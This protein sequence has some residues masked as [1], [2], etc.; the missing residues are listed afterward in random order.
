VGP[1]KPQILGI[2]DG[3]L[4][5]A[6]YLPAIASLEHLDFEADEGLLL[7]AYPGE[8]GVEIRHFLGRVEPWLKAGWRILA[9]RPE[10]YP[11]G[12]AV[13]DPSFF[14]LEDR[15]FAA[16]GAN[17]L[18]V[19]PHIRHPERGQLSFARRRLAGRKALRLQAE[20][21][22]LIRRRMRL[23]ESRPFTR[24]DVDLTRV[25]TEFSSPMPWVWS[26]VVPPNYL[27]PAF[28]DARS[29]YS[30]EDHVGVQLRSLFTS[31]EPRNSSVDEVL[32][33][34]ADICEHL[35]LPLLVYGHPHGSFL[36]DGLVNT[37]S[38]GDARLLRRELGYLRSC[39]VMLAPNSGWADLMCWLRVPTLLENRGNVEVF[40]P[41]APFAPRLV[42]RSRGEAA[43]SQAE[44]L[45][46]GES[47][48]RALG[49]DIADIRGVPDW[50][51][52]V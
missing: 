5:R 52:E 46:A 49:S 3:V 17:R 45:L 36:P 24:W 18:A 20:W 25:S 7:P 2:A 28:V 26:D 33:D 42:V 51:H 1:L 43:G 23:T 9:R 13:S 32:R 10:F 47:A 15:L 44:A 12:S 19:G 14:A 35:A 41:M 37:S 39:K 31:R 38:L 4:E 21:R 8:M 6:G 16:Y 48:F 22:K 50:V 34:A 11:E 40:R 27:P 29:P 30:Y